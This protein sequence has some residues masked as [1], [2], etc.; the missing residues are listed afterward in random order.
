[1]QWLLLVGSWVAVAIIV[2]GLMLSLKS[3]K[4]RLLNGVIGNLLLVM[5]FFS[6]TMTVIYIN[7]RR[8]SSVFIVLLILILIPIILTYLLSGIMLL[9]NALIVWR[10]ESH[11]LQNMLTLLIG[12]AII[13]SP[14]VFGMIDKYFP[15]SIAAAITAVTDV[16]VLYV[17]FWFLNFLTSFFLSRIFRPSYDKQYIIVLGAGLIKGRT[18]TPLLAARIKRAKDF[19]DLQI[20]KTGLA[21][22]IVMSGGQGPDEKVPEAQAMKEYALSLGI[23]ND[24]ILMESKSKTTL[25]NMQFSKKIL[26]NN[27]IDLSKGLFATSDFHTYRAAGYA[28]YVGL[29]INGLSAK[30]SH[31]F[32]PNALLRE[33]AAILLSHK[34]FH[35]IALAVLIT[36]SIV[37]TTTHVIPHLF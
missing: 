4:V 18:V 20:S 22:V 37:Q 9:W 13:V 19:S 11:T 27:D 5:I 12:L 24:H 25:Q 8:L 26:E 28:R 10:H 23:D 7:D 2:G 31:F 14:F 30:T 6:L 34:N 32:I 33:Y 17:V 35:I 3:N 15:S 29:N 36:F 21:P 1:M 16:I